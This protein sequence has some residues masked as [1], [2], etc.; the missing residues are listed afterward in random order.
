MSIVLHQR[1]MPFVFNVERETRVVLMLINWHRHRFVALFAPVLF[2]ALCNVAGCGPSGPDGPYPPGPEG[3]FVQHC[4]QCHAQAGQPGGP[5]G[6]GSSKGPNLA[7]IGAEPGRTADWLAEYIRDPKSKKP[8]PKLMPAFG[9]KLT[10]A[11]IRSLA[12]W[13]AAKK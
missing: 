9:D 7:R 1:R 11:E 2:I 8:D 5:P 3:L 6:I 13:L 10:D 4:S 12:A